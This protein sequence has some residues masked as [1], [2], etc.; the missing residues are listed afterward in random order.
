MP[1]AE[2]DAGAVH[3]TH[4]GVRNGAAA[5]V[6]IHGA[7][8]QGRDWPMEWRYTTNAVIG[9]GVRPISSSATFTDRPVYTVDLP[10]H[11]NSSGSAS[12]D[13]GAY[14]R[15]VS[16]FIE[17][18]PDDA[19]IPVGHSMGGGIAVMLARDPSLPI[20]GAVIIGSAA[21]LPVTDQILDGLRD[22]FEPTV[23]AIVKYCWARSAPE[24]YRATGR[25]R[26]RAAGPEVTRADFVA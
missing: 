2:T 17:T 25:R 14:V 9:V 21:R 4:N 5:L 7:G 3:Y 13:I 26:M 18:L 6:L 16:A 24:V 15:A 22:A 8:G 23:D 12:E 11:A 1:I 19:V 10:G 20:A